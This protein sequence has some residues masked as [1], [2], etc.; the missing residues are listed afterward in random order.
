[1]IYDGSFNGL[2]W[3]PGQN[4]KM[5][6]LEGLNGSPPIRNADVPRLGAHGS[7]YG[8]DTY[9]D[10]VV[11][12]GLVLKPN[13]A[14]GVTLDTLCAQVERAMVV[15]ASGTLPLTLNGGTR[16][17]NCRPVV[18]DIPRTPANAAER[19]GLAQLQFRAADPLIYDAVESVVTV[20]RANTGSVGGWTFPWT[21]PWTFGSGGSPGTVSVDISGSIDSAPWFH[22]AGPWDV[23]FELRNLT[24]GALLQVSIVM[25]ATDWVDLD[26]G[27]ETVMFQ[28]V[29]NRRNAVVQG[30]DFWT[31]PPGSNTVRLASLGATGADSAE[32]HYR[33]TYISLRA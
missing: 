10:R 6:R 1:M 27:A 18:F 24:T 32:M 19:F 29:S 7:F 14:A 26:M 5:A 11:T 30:T 9:A 4:I 28:G 3:G 31:L 20:P 2:T 16:V 25:T 33:G 8:R 15:Q 13:P 21:F 17:V 12:V 22:I 23:G